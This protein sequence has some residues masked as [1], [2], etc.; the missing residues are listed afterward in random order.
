MDMSDEASNFYIDILKEILQ[1][2]FDTGTYSIGRP[3]DSSVC[4]EAEKKEGWIVYG[5][6]RTA[7]VDEGRFMT[8]IEAAMEMLSRLC[9]EREE[10]AVKAELVMRIYQRASASREPRLSDTDM[11]SRC[12][13][14]G[15]GTSMQEEG[16]WSSFSDAPD[17]FSEDFMSEVNKPSLNDK[18]YE[19]AEI[20]DEEMKGSDGYA[21][22]IRLPLVA[23]RPLKNKHSKEADDLMSFVQSSH[24]ET[25]TDKA[26][27]ELC[28]RVTDRTTGKVTVRRCKR[29]AEGEQR[30]I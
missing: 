9:N 11:L 17:A 13:G 23:T 24:V 14:D 18:G 30:E 3:Q 22:P 21:I 8:V 26:T 5:C 1:E 10:A 6:N 19:E 27:G 2:H 25:F 12:P 16:A 28:L 4:L 15:A 20:D 29:S 7:R